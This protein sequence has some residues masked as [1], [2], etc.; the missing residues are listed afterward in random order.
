[1]NPQEDH[2]AGGYDDPA[3][4]GAIADLQEAVGDVAR[5]LRRRSPSDRDES[6][7]RLLRDAAHILELPLERS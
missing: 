2:R 3:L 5:A 1:M 4:A 7:A 6:V